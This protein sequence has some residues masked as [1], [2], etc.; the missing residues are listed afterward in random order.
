M[1]KTTE[2]ISFGGNLPKPSS[3]HIRHASRIVNGLRYYNLCYSFDISNW[4]DKY[5]KLLQEV[6]IK[7]KL[8]VDNDTDVIVNALHLISGLSLYANSNSHN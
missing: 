1:I 6:E 2:R 7:Q 4:I 3:D 8:E 5:F